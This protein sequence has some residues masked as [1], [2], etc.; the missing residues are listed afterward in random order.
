VQA[1][2]SLRYKTAAGRGLAGRQAAL[3]CTPQ[4]PVLFQELDCWSRDEHAKLST[5]QIQCLTAKICRLAA[6]CSPAGSTPPAGVQGGWIL[7][8]P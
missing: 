4:P 1:P 6:T 3:A 8:R 5:A 7:F 2:A